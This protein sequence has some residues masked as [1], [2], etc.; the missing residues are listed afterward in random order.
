MNGSFKEFYHGRATCRRIF[1]LDFIPF[2]SRDAKLIEI[3]ESNLSIVSTEE[4]DLIV[5]E[6]LAVK[7][8]RGR[9]AALLLDECALR[10]L[11]VY[12][13]EVLQLIDSIESA[14][15]IQVLVLHAVART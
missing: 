8:P 6:D 11:H 14:E 7:V 10:F 1:L 12:A 2:G 5:I 13:I 3:V 15:D 4:I 9:D